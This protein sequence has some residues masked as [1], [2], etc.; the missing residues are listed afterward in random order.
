MTLEELEKAYL[1]DESAAEFDRI[2][3]RAAIRRLAIWGS[4]LMA[5]AS[6]ALILTL[7]FHNSGRGFDGVEIADGIEQIMSL[8]TG[9]VKSVVAKPQGRRVILTVMMRDGRSCSYV[10]SRENG[11]EAFSITAMK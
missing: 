9:N 2:V 8:D 10:M 11:D 3:R 7:T 4:M 6:L 5:A 1:S